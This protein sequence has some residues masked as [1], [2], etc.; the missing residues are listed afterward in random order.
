MSARRIVR[1]P[2]PTKPVV[3]AVLAAQ[4]FSYAGDKKYVRNL[5][6]TLTELPQV[7]LPSIGYTASKWTQLIR[8][9]W[10]ECDVQRVRAALASRSSRDVTSLGLSLRG[11]AKGED[12]QG[13]CME[14]MVITQKDAGRETYVHVFWR[15]C[16]V[17]KKLAADFVFLGHMF[18]QL[19]IE[20]TTVTLTFANAWLGMTFVPLYLR[21]EPVIAFLDALKSDRTMWMSATNTLAKY[22]DPARQPKYAA[23]ARQKRFLAENWS[24]GR[25]EA[26]REYLAANGRC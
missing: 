10:N 26:A 5:S 17:I 14:L 13:W 19:G 6:V 1:P 8:N 9:Y 22:I 18:E 15:T 20:P 7:E 24:E 12:S 2:Y 3:D 23:E 21:N 11:G 4:A 16:E 25:I